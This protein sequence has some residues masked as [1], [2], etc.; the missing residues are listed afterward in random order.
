[1]TIRVRV[2]Q[3]LPACTEVLRRVHEANG[4]PGRWPRDPAGWI[5]PA[6]LM[7]AWVAE[8][9]GAIAGHT[10]LVHGMQAGCVLRATGR[11]AGELAVVARLFVDPAARRAGLARE[12]LDT[13]KAHAVAG[14]LQPVL[15]VV[16]GSHAAIALYERSGWR[17]AGRERATW[18]TP[19]GLTPML[20]Y[21][22]WP[23]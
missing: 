16:E 10:G 21:Y 12:L 6:G 1:V 2:A 5:S 18:T 9:G 3:D 17:Q 23:S 19:A 14:G 8:T 20:R 13:A 11:G 7:R 15:D 22:V 4:Y